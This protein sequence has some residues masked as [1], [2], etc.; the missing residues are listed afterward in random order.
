MKKLETENDKWLRNLFSE[1]SDKDPSMRFE[2]D[3]MRRIRLLE[4]ESR[5]KK[6]RMGILL[7]AFGVLASTIGSVVLFLLLGWSESLASSMSNLLRQFASLKFDSLALIPMFVIVMLL[8][9]DLFARKIF[10][11]E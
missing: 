8:I 5:R 6:R 11:K 10:L 2:A 4:E 9:V 7:S 1:Q 3:L